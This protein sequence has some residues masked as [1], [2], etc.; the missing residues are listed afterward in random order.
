[1]TEPVSTSTGIAV[2]VKL[3]G[4][5]FILSVAAFLAWLVVIMTRMP[6]TRSEWVVSLITTLIGSLT[7][8]AFIVQKFSLHIWAEN[9]YGAVALGGVFFIA[10]LPV[11]AIIRWVF[12]YVNDREG[13]DI[14][15]VIKEAKK[16]IK[17]IK[18]E[19]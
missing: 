16:A 18:D 5:L 4:I 13:M 14:I 9:P 11:W 12:N 7:G 6:R 3:Y 8:G 19:E 2:L 10:G 15:E 1:M 17:E